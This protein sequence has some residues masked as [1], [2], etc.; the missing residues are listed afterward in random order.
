[1]ALPESILQ[2]GTMKI[3]KLILTERDNRLLVRAMYWPVLWQWLVPWAAAQQHV[4]GALC[5]ACA[6]KVRQRRYVHEPR[7][8]ELRQI[9]C[10]KCGLPYAKW[11]ARPK[12]RGEWPKQPKRLVP[13]FVYRLAYWE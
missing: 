3:P 13:T 4:E 8:I 9:V 11:A 7:T 6:A 12:C 10:D 5:L 2:E 1:M